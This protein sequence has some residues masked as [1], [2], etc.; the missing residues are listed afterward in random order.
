MR[1]ERS[2]LDGV[3]RF[4]LEQK[5]VVALLVLLVVGW[6][7]AVAPFDWE[8]D[9]LP[10][11]P[12]PVDAIPNLGENQQIVFTEWPGRSPQDVEDQVTYPL[13]VSLLG[14]PGVREVRSSSAFGFSMIFLIF[15]EDT[16]FYWS[17]SRI[18]E[19]LNSLP[20]GLLPDAVTPALGP[21]ATALGQVYWYTLEG[22]DPDGSPAGGW[23][24][25]EL[26]SVQDWYVRYG[27]LAAEGISE[28]ASIGGYVREYQVDVDPDA[29]RAHDVTLQQVFEAVRNSNLD[30]GARVVEMN[31]V[32]Y[33]VRGLGFIDS[34]SD[35]EQAVV[36]AGPDHV[37]I[38]VSDVAVV[39]FGPA[40]RRGALTIGGAEAVG[41]VVI[42]REGYNPLRAIQNVKAKIEEIAPG[43]P[44]KAVID[45]ARVGRSEVSGFA[46]N[47]G[48]AAFGSA[49][50]DPAVARGA[51]LDQ[52]AWLAWLRATPREAWPDWVTLSRLEVVSFYDRSG[53][54]AETLSTLDDALLQQVL[55]TIV[56]VI[57]MV[58]HL[59]TALVISATVP[60]AVLIGFILMKLVGI[61]ANVVALAGIAIAI[62]T[63][64]DM[65]VIVTENVLKHLNEAGPDEPRL[66]VVFRG[67]SEVGGAILAAIS[68]T[69]ISFLPVFTMTGAEGKMFIPLAFTKT[70]VL[71][72]A[73]FITLTVVPAAAHLL[74][75]GRD[76][77]S[78]T[79][80][81]RRTLLFGLGIAAAALTLLGVLAGWPAV[82]G[83]GLVLLLVVAY[84]LWSPGLDRWLGSRAPRLAAALRRAEAAV[85]RGGPWLA[86][87]VAALVVWW[88]LGAIWEPLGPEAGV[89]LN[90]VFVGLVI[91][92]IL[93]L[94]W[95]LMLVY[96]AVLRW[97]LA[98]KLLFLSLPLVLVLAGGSI[99]LG[100]D[101]VFGFLPAA[102][103]RVGMDAQSVRSSPPW[104]WASH[105]FPGLGREFMPPLDEGSFLWMPTTMPHASMGEILAV[106]KH[107][108]LAILSV[109]EVELV[110]GKLGRAETALDPAPISMLESV[111]H[112]KP[113]YVTDEAGRRINFRYDRRHGEFVRD[114]DGELIPD[115]RGRPYRQWRDHIRSPQDIWDE[116][117]KAA[118]L[119]GTTSA[120]K[121][122]P[123]E[124]RLVM[125]QTG[126]RA[127]MGLKVRAADLE[128]LDRIAVTL[129]RELRQI[130]AIRPDTV[131]ADRVVGKPYLEIDIDREAIARYGLNITDVQQLI[132]VAIGGRN[133]T[134]TVEGRERYPVR[135]R[136]QRELRTEIEDLEAV[137][138]SAP[139]GTQVPLSE[140]A[141]ITYTRGPQMI[142]SEDTFLTAY[143]TFGGQPGIAEVE[144]VE[145]AQAYLQSRIDAGEL[146]VP[147]GVNWKFSGN[148]EHQLRAA[149]TLRIVLP[150]ALLTIFLILYFQFRSVGTTLIVFSGIAV[151]W[152]GGFILIWLYGEPW[153]AN[154]S[155]FGTNM[156][157]L[158]QMGTINLSVAV[159]VGFLALFGIAVDNGV[160]LAT[161]LRQSFERRRTE[162]VP[163]LRAATVVAGQRR[164]RPCL[165]TT[166]TTVLALLPV[167]TST[168]RG[169]D[170]MIPMA[171]PSVGGMA[172][173]LL[174]M[175]TVPVL[176]CW[177]E[178]IRLKAR[179]GEYRDL[180]AE[181][182]G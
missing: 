101:R 140:V 178:E 175:F 80:A 138:I 23:D 161:Y 112:Y 82:A 121:L 167:L 102:A 72:G 43:L 39:N 144:V 84:R 182:T 114:S 120:P 97:C 38:R 172:M 107:Q 127:P 115:R 56:V 65:S 154:F 104:S 98:H 160:V 88:V 131:N 162:T 86:S 81:L 133:I 177:V 57:I 170:I 147:A 157:E 109:P 49:G 103:Q 92:G 2:F 136:Y 128:T 18:I 28:V 159:W 124:T 90:F 165:M 46:G 3:I 79:P 137:L 123:I 153:F 52:E 36:R 16:E 99:W 21:D 143:V 4:F 94:F 70:F 45:W 10:R 74:I 150:V 129:E 77:S 73:I 9:W 55:V 95:L 20:A 96:S 35:L 151:A 148:Y 166:A 119:P 26:R 14:V 1:N 7:V 6:G 11:D 64:V 135:V 117:V 105:R 176:Y 164:V 126:M 24:L 50:Q 32:E 149:R 22:R 110:A 5:L 130:P 47:A 34:L 63:I 62:G 8:V 58:L 125:L 168:G 145:Q 83:A 29:L 68:T 134:T 171:I 113:E 17:R 173:V 174:T 42:V 69:I 158:F 67:T 30:V 163:E 31:R 12:V 75:A 108:D 106:L 169:S 91:G 51:E 122:Q 111:I 37:P 180:P 181:P 155:I 60:L 66:E 13:T 152:A 89:L 132:T 93:A 85:A 146:S 33:L 44:A 25:D 54:I 139:D 100:F 87:V 141:Q 41:G 61:D 19:K 142:R 179:I 76:R 40:Q 116:I 156:R 78:A 71:L 53:L 15:D 48:F 27:L 59:R 118:A